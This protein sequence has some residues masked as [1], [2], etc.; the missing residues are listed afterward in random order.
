M[1]RWRGWH[2]GDRACEVVGPGRAPGRDQ[3]RELSKEGR[4]S[5]AGSLQEPQSH[6]E[7]GRAHQLMMEHAHRPADTR[8]GGQQPGSPPAR[9]WSRRGSLRR[10]C[11][12]RPERFHSGHRRAN[13]RRRGHLHGAPPTD[14]P[15]SRRSALPCWAISAGRQ[16]PFTSSGKDVQAVVEEGA[17]KDLRPQGLPGAPH[18]ARQ[19]NQSMEGAIARMRRTTPGCAPPRFCVTTMAR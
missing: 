15:P 2:R 3:A 13:A 5:H 12:R 9:T 4:G 19:P 18:A 8:H 6:G 16:R 11:I 10:I 17:G 14:L 7:P 1:A